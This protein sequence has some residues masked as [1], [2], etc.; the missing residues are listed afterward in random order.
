M[1]GCKVF[2]PSGVA[3][4]IEIPVDE[5]K[6]LF[7]IAFLEASGASDLMSVVWIAGE[8]ELLVK[9]SA[10]QIAVTDGFVLVQIPVYTKQSGDASVVVPFA[11]GR[12]AAPQGLI[13]AT[14]TVPRGPHIVI[15][16]WGEALIAAAWRALLHLTSSLAAAAG[17]DE[18]GNVL[19]PVSFAANAGGI[20]I[21][22]QARHRFDLGRS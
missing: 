3:S 14:E 21:T 19:L 16:L 13:M 10:V 18:Q 12:D 11:V 1:P 9:T 6:E 5:A 8:S 22:P 17:V 15:E 20:R 4:S 2:G 7:R